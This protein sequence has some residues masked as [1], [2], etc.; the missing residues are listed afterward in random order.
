MTSNLEIKNNCVEK[1]KWNMKCTF[2]FHACN[3]KLLKVQDG[4]I[5]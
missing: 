4:L 5:L 3:N 2:I 1:L